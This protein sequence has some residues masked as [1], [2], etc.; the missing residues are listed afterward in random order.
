MLRTLHNH[1]ENNIE[2]KEEKP[3]DPEIFFQELVD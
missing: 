2:N 1:L 3:K